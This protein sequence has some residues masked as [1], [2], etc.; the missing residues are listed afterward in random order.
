MRRAVDPCQGLMLAECA[1]ELLVFA[2]FYGTYEASRHNMI[3]DTLFALVEYTAVLTLFLAFRLMFGALDLY[4]RWRGCQG[5]DVHRAILAAMAG[6]ALTL[7]GWAWLC[8]HHEGPNHLSGVG[9]FAAGTL[10]YSI[11][12]VR[13]ARLTD[14]H[15]RLDTLYFALDLALLGLTA[16]LGVGFAC[17][18]FQDMAATYIVEHAA[19]A[20]NLVFWMVFFTFHWVGP[21]PGQE[22]CRTFHMPAQCQPLLPVVDPG[23]GR[24]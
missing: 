20:A 3:S 2:G 9:V 8:V 23:Q 1:L 11:G 18:W 16:G 14:H 7:L 12:L 13:V 21:L 19:Y 22:Q 10:L 15:L 4:R 24:V 5:P 6:F 17:M